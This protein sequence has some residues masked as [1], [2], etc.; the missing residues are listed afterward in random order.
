MQQHFKLLLLLFALALPCEAKVHVLTYS[1]MLDKGGLGDEIKKSAEAKSLDV[2]F[3]TS[4][5]FS[6]MIG[7]LR[8][9]KREGKLSDVDVVLGLNESNYITAFTEGLIQRGNPFEETSF[10][11]LVNKEKFPQTLWPK[12]WAEAKDKLAGKILIQDPRTSEVGLTWML[13]AT[14]LKNL[15]LDDAKKMPRK[16]FPTWSASFKA[17]ESN[18]APAI[19]TYS[20]SAA[21]YKCTNDPKSQNFVNLPLPSYPK[22]K[23]FVARVSNSA[24]KE[25]SD[26]VNLVMSAAVQNKIWEKNWTIPA[27][28]PRE[29]KKMPTCFSKV[30]LPEDAK[31]LGSTAPK[32][33]LKQLDQW[34]L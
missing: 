27:S 10:S 17:F 25:A 16:I 26:F 4:K 15:S 5:D 3:Q 9:L 23:N 21:Y 34:N 31:V 2:E 7:T 11:I 32:S 29:I 22:D 14:T 24:N 30:W 20:T 6:G 19:W 18:L 1:S 28:F 12:T 33:L 8:R 13:N